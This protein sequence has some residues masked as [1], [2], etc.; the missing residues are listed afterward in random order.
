M[1]SHYKEFIN[2]SD[3]NNYCFMPFV[4]VSTIGY[5]NQTLKYPQ[6]A[7][8]S[9]W[10]GLNGKW[11]GLA[12]NILLCFFGMTVNGL[13]GVVSI[14][15][16]VLRSENITPAII[17]LVGAN[18]LSCLTGL[19]YYLLFSFSSDFTFQVQIVC[20]LIAAFGYGLVICSIFN[21]LGIGLCKFIRL[22]FLTTAKEENFRRACTFV[23]GLA[24]IVSFLVSF[25]TAI[26]RWGQIHFECNSRF[27][28][29]ININADGSHTG[30]SVATIYYSS[31]I[32]VGILN[33][34]LNI[35]IYYK[36]RS[37]IKTIKTEASHIGNLSTVMTMKYMKKERKAVKLMGADSVLYAIFPIPRA[38]LFILEPY[39]RTTI[40]WLSKATLTLWG[41]TAVI[42]PILLLIF[43][44]KYRREIKKILKITYLSTINKFTTSHSTVNTHVTNQC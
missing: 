2:S 9:D 12:I 42:E 35:A 44:E 37:Y 43:Q 21:I 11:L 31:Y 8:L 18:F 24:W 5:I 15:D 40:E 10:I 30:Y 34:L 32:V 4:N 27:C 28:A 16:K 1:A 3:S 33:I 22:Y 19:L 23:A 39:A 17:S 20:K 7:P 13:I 6:V 14:K 41:L 25:P 38:I 29:I 26:G 36:I